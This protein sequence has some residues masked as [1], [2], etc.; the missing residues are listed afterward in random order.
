MAVDDRHK[1]YIVLPVSTFIHYIN[2][3]TIE[4]NISYYT[5]LITLGLVFRF[6]FY[7]VA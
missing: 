5:T 6:K 1:K 4:F 2:T 7:L 3:V